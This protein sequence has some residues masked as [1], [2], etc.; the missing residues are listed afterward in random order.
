M[1]RVASW[2]VNGIRAAVRKGF[3][4][5]VKKLDPDILGLQEVKADAPPE[6]PPEFA[7][8]KVFW[9]PGEKKGYAGVAVLTKREPKAVR[10]GLG[11]PEFDA[12]GRVIT[13]EFDDFYLVN[14]YFPNAGRGLVRLDFKLDFDRAIERY[15]EELKKK[16]G[17]VLLGDLNVAHREI[18]LARPKDNV[19]N[20]GFTPEERAWIDAFLKKGWVDTFRAK[21]PEEKGA[22]TWWSYRFNA[23]DKNIGWRVDYVLL[24]EDLLPKLKDAYI[25]KDT[26]ASDHV[27]AVA[28]LEL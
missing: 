1:L 12:E 26:R 11:V 10:F 6:L 15:L 7:G 21:H 24:S 17:V 8:Y 16:K 5:A 22:Y 13:L 20:A 28:E 2:N 14:T 9:H 19:K 4:E 25:F 27:P 23:R 18:D 3:W